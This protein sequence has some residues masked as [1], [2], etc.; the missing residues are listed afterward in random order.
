M[1]KKISPNKFQISLSSQDNV[2]LHPIHKHGQALH[3]LMVLHILLGEGPV[4]ING[5]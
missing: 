4:E 1:A 2:V 3:G 5:T